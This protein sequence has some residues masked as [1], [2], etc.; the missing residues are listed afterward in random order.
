LCNIA[1]LEMLLDKQRYDESKPTITG[2]ENDFQRYLH[3]EIADEEST[4]DYLYTAIQ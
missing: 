1:E 3:V 4:T 2:W